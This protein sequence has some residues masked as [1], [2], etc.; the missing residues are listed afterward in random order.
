[1]FKILLVCA[2]VG[3][4]AAYPGQLDDVNA[5]VIS[6]SEDI[7]PDGFNTHLEISNG[8]KEDRAGDE[9]GNIRGSFSFDTPEDE[10][11]E[12]SYIADENGYQPT[13][14]VLPTPPPIPVE[15]QRALEW[16]AAHPYNG[17]H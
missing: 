15:I 11:V 10:P 8:I 3:L 9:H 4:A 2:L 16:I 13:G 14:A 5:E 6:R 17:E 1:M 7:R 12:I